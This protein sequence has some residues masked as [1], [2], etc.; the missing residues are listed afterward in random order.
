MLSPALLLG[1]WKNMALGTSAC[2]TIQGE[3]SERGKEGGGLAG[4]WGGGKEAGRGGE[5]VSLS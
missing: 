2:L 5:A 4:V 3:V 1:D